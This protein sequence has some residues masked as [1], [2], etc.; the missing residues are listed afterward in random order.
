MSRDWC[1]ASAHGIRLAV[2]IIPNAK[3]TEVTGIQDDALKIRL[4]A[5]ALE[6]KANE[7]LIRFLAD[8]LGVPKSAVHITHGH[9]ARRKL[10]EVEAALAPVDAKTVLLP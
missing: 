9:T 7:A 5:P 3:K 4:Q 6:G 10:V 8:A 1:S 2:H